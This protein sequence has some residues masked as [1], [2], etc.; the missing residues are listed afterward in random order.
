MERER[1]REMIIILLYYGIVYHTILAS[2]PKGAR[3]QE[4]HEVPTTTTNNNNNNDHNNTNNT[5]KHD[6]HRNNYY[7]IPRVARLEELHEV[8]QVLLQIFGRHSARLSGH[9]AWHENKNRQITEQ[10]TE[11]QQRVS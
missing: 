11:K 3:L 4:L 1:E 8:H 10:Q 2:L 9:V 7:H 5:N 6:N